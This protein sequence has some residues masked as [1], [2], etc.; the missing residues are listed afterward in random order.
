MKITWRAGEARISYVHLAGNLCAI[1]QALHDDAVWA[2]L[3]NFSVQRANFTRTTHSPRGVQSNE[4]DKKKHSQY[5][6][7]INSC[8]QHGVNDKIQTKLSGRRILECGR[9]IGVNLPKLED[10]AVDV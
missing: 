2:R 9:K 8:L 4:R 1:R 10:V 5:R 7:P 6:A 3:L